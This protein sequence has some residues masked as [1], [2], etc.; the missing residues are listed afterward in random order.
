MIHAFF[1]NNVI[2]LTKGKKGYWEVTNKHDVFII[3]GKGVNVA[4]ELFKLIVNYI[5]LSL[6]NGRLV[7]IACILIRLC[8]ES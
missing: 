7:L 4:A 5:N 6:N 3:F 1:M 8:Q 2:F